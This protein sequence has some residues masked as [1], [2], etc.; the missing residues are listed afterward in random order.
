[1]RLRE[2]LSR[3]LSRQGSEIFEKRESEKVNH[4]SAGIDSG[5]ESERLTTLQRASRVSRLHSIAEISRLNLR[6]G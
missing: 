4:Q 2:V 5:E 3:R 1:M 6:V